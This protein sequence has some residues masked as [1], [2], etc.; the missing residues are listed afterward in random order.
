MSVF[1]VLNLSVEIEKRQVLKK[2]SF[3]V[4]EGEVVA[5]VGANGGGK[6]SL[7]KAVLGIEEYKAVGGRIRLSGK[8]LLKMGISERSRVGLYVAYQNPVSL[9]GVKV[10]TLC[11]TL[12][13]SH[14]HTIDN[15][16]EFR[17]MLEELAIRVGLKREHIGRAVNEGF[18]GGE[19]KRL[20]I[21]QLL[22]LKP[23]VA[24]LDE[25][26]SG[27]DAQGREMVSKVIIEMSKEGV[28]FLIIS[29]NNSFIEDLGVTRI[30]KM[31]DGQIQAK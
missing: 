31:R 20:E 25:V 10:F 8:Q 13:E 1:S 6:S 17:D 30:W 3:E 16:V 15:V 18:S 24:I 9:P 7:A 26:D 11:K 5:L 4:S 21:L 14:G 28:A 27:L 29:H 12:Y 2:V 22:L 19:K 23:K